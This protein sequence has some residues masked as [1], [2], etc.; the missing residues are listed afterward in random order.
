MSQIV[1][2]TMLRVG[3]FDANHFCQA[4]SAVR[5]AF[6]DFIGV[7]SMALQNV[8]GDFGRCSNLE[9]ACQ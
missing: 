8:R 6:P 9:A 5:F 7:N 2:V 4:E 3:R 1:H